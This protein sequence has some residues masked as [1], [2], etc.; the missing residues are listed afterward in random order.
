MAEPNGQYFPGSKGSCTSFNSE[1]EIKTFSE[2][3]VSLLTI[4]FDKELLKD[5]LCVLFFF[6][7]T[8]REGVGNKKKL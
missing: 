4:Y 5:I 6:K 7:W 3:E 1:N 2:K 8:Q